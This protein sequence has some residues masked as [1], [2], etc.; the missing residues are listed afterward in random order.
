MDSPRS[1]TETWSAALAAFLSADQHRRTR[2]GQ[3]GGN[4]EIQVPLTGVFFFT[5]DGTSGWPEPE[6][7]GDLV[8][9][10]SAGGTAE[11][12]GGTGNRR[13]WKEGEDVQ[14]ERE[15]HVIHEVLGRGADGG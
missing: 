1:R 7:D 10:R 4:D 12:R 5:R 2:N 3:A 8:A 6:A 14:A 15:K 11:R 13:Q 9:G